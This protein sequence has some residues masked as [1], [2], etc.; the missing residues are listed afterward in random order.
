MLLCAATYTGLILII[1]FRQ[2]KTG[3]YEPGE[4]NREVSRL[5]DVRTWEGPDQR[6]TL[7]ERVI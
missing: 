1:K 5:G 3:F 2:K 4:L 7:M 6:K